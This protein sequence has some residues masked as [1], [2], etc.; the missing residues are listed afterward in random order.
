MKYLVMKR[1]NLDDVPV[2]LASNQVDA[3]K[4]VV[5]LLEGDLEATEADEATL[6]T[7]IGSN[8]I[9]VTVVTFDD[10]GH[11]TGSEIYPVEED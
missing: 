4:M 7:N 6:Q 3:L 2:F 10:D 11:I 9:A 5:D 1:F 8:L